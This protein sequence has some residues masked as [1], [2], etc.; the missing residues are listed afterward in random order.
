M[1][2]TFGSH[3]GSWVHAL[4]V[5]FSASWL[6]GCS[7]S[8]GESTGPSAG[9]APP[10]T[11][12]VPS[13][14]GAFSAF[15]EASAVVAY[16]GGYV[17][18][19]NES[20]GA[21][22]PFSEQMTARDLP[23]PAEV[24]VRDVEALV[25]MPRGLRSAGSQSTK[26]N[27]EVRPKRERVQIVGKKWAPVDF[28]GCDE[29]AAARGKPPKMGGL[30]VEG[31]AFWNGGLWFGLRSPLVQKKAIL[32]KMA[33]DPATGLTVSEKVQIDLNEFGIRDLTVHNGALWIL[34]GPAD[35]SLSAHRLYSLAE[36]TAAPAL[37]RSN[38]PERSEG[39][40]FGPNGALLVVTDGKGKPGEAC[41]VAS[42]WRWI[43]PL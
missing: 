33:G 3:S 8:T 24:D 36:K 5:A 39:I 29:C 20:D 14:Q 35:E 1:N 30:S 9:S 15:C 27:G 37:V 34:A 6:F 42:T 26:D 23:R 7:A 43:S 40:T 16:Q 2:R 17:V 11:S 32:L 28:A 21:I 12:S 18:A 4:A 41:T 19:D 22:Y 10:N 25:A 13:N 31:A 38:L